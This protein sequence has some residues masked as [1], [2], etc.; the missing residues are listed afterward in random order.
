[1][2]AA[3]GQPPRSAESLFREKTSLSVDHEAFVRGLRAEE[4]QL[5]V[6]RNELYDGSWEDM[7]RD[8]EDRRD[9]KPY[10]YKLINKIDED[11]ARIGQLKQYEQRHGIDL[12]DFLDDE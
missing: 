3:A 5:L 2:S 7:T 9:G 12:G 4:V 10:I 8:L 1:M 11:L 6:I